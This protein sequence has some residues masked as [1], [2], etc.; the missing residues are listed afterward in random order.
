MRGVV[1]LLQKRNEDAAKEF[2]RALELRPN[3]VTPR[4]YLAAI[5]R[6]KGDHSEAAREYKALADAA[7]GIPAGY[8]GQA[9]AHMMLRNPSEAFR[10]LQ[11]WKAVPRSGSLPYH[12]IANVYIAQKE[13]AKAIQ[14]LQAAV[15]KYPSDTASLTYLGDAYLALKDTQ[16]AIDSYRLAIK[17]DARNA[18]ATNNLA[19]VLM[20]GARDATALNESLN[21]AE[22]AVKLEPT[23]VDAL[24]TLGWVHYR[25]AD[26][27]KSIAA[28]NQAR[29]LAPNRMDVAAHLGLAY[30]KAG[31]KPQALTELRAALA[32]KATIANRAELER[33]V[34]ELASAP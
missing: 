6:S 28:L 34:K 7:P 30:A 16:K 17:A 27:A 10:V 21:L 29:K 18:V 14:E 26:Y 19:W 13:P 20:D 22:A 5:A 8:L 2:R 32:S 11:A 31:Q 1:L 25:R 33:T 4:F 12:V 24:D 15:A 3:Y 23:Y 9:E